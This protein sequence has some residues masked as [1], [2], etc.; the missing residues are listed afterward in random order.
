MTVVKSIVAGLVSM[1]LGAVLLTLG[2]LITLAAVLS[3]ETNWAIYF[4]SVALNSP[5]LWVIEV[6]FFAL[7]FHWEFRRA[8]LRQSK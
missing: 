6:L 8:R 5:L 1:A 3:P 7:G 4:V 2:A